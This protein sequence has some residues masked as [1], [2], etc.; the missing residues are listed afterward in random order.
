MPLFSGIPTD[1]STKARHRLKRK[2]RKNPCTAQ[3]W[4]FHGKISLFNLQPGRRRRFRPGAGDT[5][6]AA[7][8]LRAQSGA[9]G[10]RCGVSRP[11][12]GYL[13]YLRPTEAILALKSPSPAAATAKP[14]RLR[15]LGAKG[16]PGIA[17]QDRLPGHRNYYIGND[18]ARWHTRV[19]TYVRVAATGV[20][21]GIDMVYYGKDGKLEY[22]FRVAAGADP[23]AIRLGFDGVDKLEVNHKGELLL[24]AGKARLVQH[25]PYAYQNIG[26]KQVAVTARYALRGR[27][28]TL[29]L[30]DYDHRRPLIIDPA[31]SY[32]S[33]LGGSGK[34]EAQAVAVDA[35]GNIY[36]TGWTESA[37]FPQAMATTGTT[38]NASA[39]G[40]NSDAFVTMFNKSGAIVFSTYLGSAGSNNVPSYPEGG[41]GI[42]VSNNGKIYVT[43]GTAS[44][45]T[46]DYFPTNGSQAPYQTCNL[47]FINYAFVSILNN[48]DGSLYYSTCIGQPSNF[49]Q[50]GT[51]IAVD[52]TGDAYVV[53]WTTSGHN[54]SPSCQTDACLFPTTPPGALQTVKD[55][56]AALRSSFFFKLDPTLGTNGLIYST[57][58]G[59]TLDATATC[60]DT[61]ATA[62]AVDSSNYA[63]VAGWTGVSAADLPTGFPTATTTT[64]YRAALNGT[65]DAF[66]Y[67][68]NPD[69]NGTG[70]SNLLYATYFGGSDTSNGTVVDKATGIAVDTAGNIYIAGAT[71]SNSNFPFTAGAFQTTYGGGTTL[72]DAYIAKFTPTAPA[73]NDYILSYSTYLGG[74]GEDGATGIA[75]DSATGRAYVTGGTTS[76]DFPLRNAAALQ[77]AFNKNNN[78]TARDAFA[79]SLELDGK[80]LHYSTYLG[81]SLDD[82]GQ[83]IAVAS[84]DKAY[85]VG[86]TASPSTGTT[87]Q[88]IAQS[89]PFTDNA[90]QKTNNS[91]LGFDAFVTRIAPVANLSVTIAAHATN[92]LTNTAPPV[93]GSLT[94][95]LIVANLGPDP[96]TGINLTLALSTPDSPGATTPLLNPVSDPTICQYDGNKQFTCTLPDLAVGAQQTISISGTLIYGSQLVATA[97]V[98]S[99]EIDAVSASYSLIAS[100]PLLPPSTTVTG[101]GSTTAPSTSASGGGGVIGAP[102]LLLLMLA[103]FVKAFARWRSVALRRELST[104]AV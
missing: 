59:S 42:A 38:L 14:I 30:G 87:A 13:L 46:G 41:Y 90:V 18:P 27:T 3:V 83:A 4:P 54:Q 66:F 56:P 80:S 17:G 101:G 60:C 81:G 16:H 29:A 75:V 37:D 55:T 9:G 69:P 28:V 67:K 12:Q 39:S 64:P 89:F 49:A 78:A 15:L 102:L 76:T 68:I 31:L 52:N 35:D 96:A 91:G 79:A 34:D 47:T 103:T 45:V 70:T 23:R 72:G 65:Q 53:G 57:Y 7:P 22:D 8:G 63:Y 95:S 50:V 44:N 20:Y 84:G 100:Q 92:D 6:T 97:T 98:S 2:Y 24:T 10:Q 5:P 77:T 1:F 61:Y 43:G 71:T 26:S 11:G 104:A 40:N 86:Y 62:V 93:N 99:N 94:Y 58:L 36:V 48:T 19:P 51:G 88:S 21:P 82:Q 33:Y 25:A 85:V 32:S 73:S 74:S